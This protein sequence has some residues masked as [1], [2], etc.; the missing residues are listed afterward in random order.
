MSD[1]ETKYILL[2][3]DSGFELQEKVNSCLPDGYFPQG[4]PL[5]LYTQWENERKGYTESSTIFYQA[6]FKQPSTP[7]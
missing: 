4:G 2:E 5:V 6:V 1:T 7:Q 3:A